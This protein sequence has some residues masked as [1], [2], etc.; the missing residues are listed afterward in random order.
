MYGLGCGR[1]IICTTSLFVKYKHAL[2]RLTTG[3]DVC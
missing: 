1:I 3:V 2:I